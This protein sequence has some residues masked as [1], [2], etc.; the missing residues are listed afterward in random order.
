VAMG[1]PAA[2]LMGQ[3]LESELFGVRAAD[4]W[5]LTLTSLSLVGCGLLAIWR[6]AL[7]AARTDPAIALRSD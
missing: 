3:L 4:P 6:P 5:L 1:V 7:R 2:A